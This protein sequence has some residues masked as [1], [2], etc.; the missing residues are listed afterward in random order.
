MA[1]AG[2]ESADRRTGGSRTVCNPLFCPVRDVRSFFHICYR[3]FC[4]GISSGGNGLEPGGPVEKGP[5]GFFQAACG[6]RYAADGHRSFLGGC[7][8]AGKR[9][10]GGRRFLFTGCPLPAVLECMERNRAKRLAG[11]FGRG[12]VCLF[13]GYG[14]SGCFRFLWVAGI[15][16]SAVVLVLPVLCGFGMLLLHCGPNCTVR[17]N[18]RKCCFAWWAPERCPS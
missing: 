12:A 1:E 5:G 15:Y 7:A 16:C 18:G 2:S 3:R 4:R 6:R 11:I 14:K 13:F 9:S 17:E 8:S 10:A